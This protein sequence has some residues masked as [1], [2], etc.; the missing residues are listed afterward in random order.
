MHP[1]RCMNSLPHLFSCPDPTQKRGKGSG[2]FG[3]FL[4]LAA[5]WARANTGVV[6][7]ILDLIGRRS[8]ARGPTI[9]IY[10]AGNGAAVGESNDY[11]KPA[12][13]LERSES[14]P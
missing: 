6:K 9:Q 2:E 14:F 3:P 1:L 12:I 13:S 8:W 4:G 7:Q 10:T 11:A 5:Q